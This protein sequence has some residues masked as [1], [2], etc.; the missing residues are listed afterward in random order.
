[1]IIVFVV[2][3]G[4]GLFCWNQF[5]TKRWNTGL[6]VQ[7]LFSCEHVCVGQRFTLT[8]MISNRKHLPV[9]VLEIGFRVPT[10]I[11]FTDA[12]NTTVSDYIYK[13]DVFS[14]LGME[15]ITRRYHMEPVARGRYRV[16]QIVCEAPSLLHMSSSR[17]EPELPDQEL[18][19][20]A[21]RVDVSRIMM[22]I[23]AVLGEVESTRKTYEDPFAFA[24]I[25]EYTIQDPMKTI[26]WKASARSGGL[27]V[28]TYTS[29]K[30]MNVRIFLD[31]ED[32]GIL[33]YPSLV[34]ES[35]SIAATLCMK[36]LRQGRQL[37][38]SVNV[39]PEGLSDQG[40]LPASD[41]VRFTENSGEVFH[42]RLEEFLTQDFSASRIIPFAQ[43]LRE[44]DEM[45]RGKI[46]QEDQ[47]QVLISKNAASQSAQIRSAVKN[48]SGSILVVPYRKGLPM[49]GTDTGIRTI[50]WEGMN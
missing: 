1:M 38:L 40:N 26:N 4:I 13:R 41:F 45:N 50:I 43:M 28:N 49:P 23:E 30:A 22:G 47:I 6:D 29:M 33:K 14:L 20:Y 8:E 19:A 31:L 17:A 5:Y 46:R 21:R 27:M 48:V 34:E 15:S 16:S 12:E 18:L 35:I 3:L 2:L 11:R 39:D 7:V 44:T 25:R 32:S 36:L 9:P 24:G 42:Q 37:S 10:G